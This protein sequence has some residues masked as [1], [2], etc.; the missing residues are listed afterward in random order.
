[1][2][3]TQT[4]I[5]D[6]L[7]FMRD[8]PTSAAESSPAGE[9]DLRELRRREVR[10]LSPVASPQRSSRTAGGVVVAGFHSEWD[11]ARLLAPPASAASWR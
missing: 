8:R 10:R 7:R 1:M 6:A 3:P 2:D 11:L 5:D 9:A 4:M